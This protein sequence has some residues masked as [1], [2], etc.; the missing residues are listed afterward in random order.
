M[1]LP[2]SGE[3]SIERDY[4]CIIIVPIKLLFS[5]D[6]YDHD[7]DRIVWNI[8]SIL[9][10]KCVLLVERSANFSVEFL[11][12]LCIFRLANDTQ[13]PRQDLHRRH[14]QKGH[15]MYLGF[16]YHISSYD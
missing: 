5:S 6:H 7:D 9:F 8:G 14:P 1:A 10:V 3:R 15:K 13:V 16:Q 11:F 12:L 4:I 2:L